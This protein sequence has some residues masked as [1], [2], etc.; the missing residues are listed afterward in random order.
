VDLAVVA[1]PGAAGAPEPPRRQT[2]RVE[3]RAGWTGP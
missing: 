1:D 2:L 3:V